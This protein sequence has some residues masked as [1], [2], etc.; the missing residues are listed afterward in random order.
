MPTPLVSVII[1]CYNVEKYLTEC[2]DSV[3]NQ[4]LK[5][6][7]IICINDKS[8]DS[9]GKIIDD[10]ASKYNNIK[11]I[12]HKK[13]LGLAPAR[14]TGIKNATGEY[15]YFLDSD[16]ILA[17]NA[18]ESMHSKATLTKSNMVIGDLKEFYQNK[19]ETLRFYNQKASKSFIKDF[20]SLPST[21]TIKD[22]YS[23]KNQVLAYEKLYF[24][25]ACVKLFKR[26]I[27]E[28]NNLLAPD[29]RCAEDFIMVKKFIHLC[30]NITTTDDLILFYRKHSESFTSTRKPYVFDV[31]KS[32]QPAIGMYK[33]T[34]YLEQEYTN[35]HKFFINSFVYH[36]HIFTPYKLMPKFYWKLNRAVSKWDKSKIKRNELDEREK[37]LINY[38][39]KPAPIFIIISVLKGISIILK[40]AT[41]KIRKLIACFAWSKK[42]RNKIRG[43]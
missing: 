22:L 5:N 42:L 37:S 6:I 10:Y 1:P 7:E 3:I 21:F 36:L 19:K 28:E 23:T 13:N 25:V 20:K 39:G 8:P 11:A 24:M 14:N 2:I 9:C 34:G 27:F 41:R 38:Y 4:S 31:F 16:D 29:L 17:Q 33:K 32:Y 12:H 40:P 26:K 18:L 15:I 43:K 30:G 35:L